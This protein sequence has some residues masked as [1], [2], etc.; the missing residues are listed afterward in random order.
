MQIS[1]IETVQPLCSLSW[2]EVLS[3]MSTLMGIQ[4]FFV[5][6]LVRNLKDRLSRVNIIILHLCAMHDIIIHLNLPF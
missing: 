3:L 2:S 5:F 4:T 1:C 6:N